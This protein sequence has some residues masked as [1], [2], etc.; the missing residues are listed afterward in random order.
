MISKKNYD[1]GG[2]VHDIHADNYYEL[3]KKMDAII[4]TRLGTMKT[5]IVVCPECQGMGWKVEE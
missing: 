4:K 5:K 1:Y 3:E 2:K